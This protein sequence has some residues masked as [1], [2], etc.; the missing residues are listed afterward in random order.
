MTTI[1]T[2][3]AR[4]TTCCAKKLAYT[5]LP[6]LIFILGTSVA[7]A[8]PSPNDDGAVTVF[9][10]N[11][12]PTLDIPFVQG[13]LKLD[14]LLDEAL[15]REAAIAANF[16]ESNP[17]ERALPPIGIR[18][19]MAY[20]EEYLYVAY[21]IEDDPSEIRA[22]YSDR[23]HIWQD[24]YVGML[25]DT[26]GDGQTTYFIASNPLGIQGDTRSSGNNE[27]DSFDLIF[28]SAGRITDTGYQVEMAIPFRS[29]RFPE[30]DLQE[31]RATFWITRPREDRNTYSWAGINRSDP[32]FSCQFGYLRGMSNIKRGRNLEILPAVTGSQAGARDWN[33]PG[34]GF[35]NGRVTAEPSLNIKYGLTSDLLLDATIN[36]DFSQIESDAA[37]IDVNSPF[38]LSYPERRAF[39]QE[40]ADL[41]QTQIDAVYTRSIND[42]IAASKLSG[43]FGDWTVGYIGAR[44]QTSPILLPFEESSALVS[45]GKSV[46]N[47]VRA[48]RSFENSSYVAGLVTDRRLDDGGTGSVMGVDGNL[49]FRT[50]YYFAW[51][52]LASRTQEANDATLSASLGDRTFDRGRYTAA[53]DGERFWGHG[54]NLNAGRGGRNWGFDL[55]WEQ[56]SPTFRT[57]N[58][59]V[60]SNDYRR[61]HAMTRYSFFTE[62]SRFMNR[63]NVWTG[64]C[65]FWNFD[66]VRKDESLFV[67][68]NLQL[69]RQTWVNFNVFTSNE[70]FAGVEF[71]GIERAN[72]NINSN[73]SERVQAGLQM[74]AGDSI[75]RNRSNPEMGGLLN[76]GFNLTVKPTPRMTVFSNLNHSRLRNRTTN[77]NYFSGY[78]ARTRVNYQFTR[79]LL[80]RVIVQYNDF[81]QRLDV[82]PLVTYRIS[83]FTVFHVGSTHQFAEFPARMGNVGDES[84]V[85]QQTQRQF[86]F[87]LQYLFR[88]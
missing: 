3:C 6:V 50:K 44:D 70:L 83:P 17:A 35:D 29:L 49:R 63:A 4:V 57:D 41:F 64:A 9:Q 67:G 54:L 39:F 38:A 13:G 42:P 76:L 32:C 71:K 58:G 15:W 75:Y 30:A 18:T 37:Q 19:L 78:V 24:D 56:A 28:D 52:A 46:S 23:D 86:F 7:Q 53:L 16:S 81:S 80:T 27:D 8:Q 34:S 48:R 10:A 79:K 43:R 65:R 5:W 87:K 72:L 33:V 59:F 61:A 88:M 2:A 74:N 26:N 20:D 77:E 73:F 14:G 21:V 1:H 36:P 66:N 68:M 11:L 12:L 55:I 62:N 84:L 25:L 69:K 82:D 31:W 22:N 60:T 47:I 85:F 40:G 45:G 51:Q